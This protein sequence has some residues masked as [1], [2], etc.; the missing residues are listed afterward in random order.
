M[1]RFFL[2]ITYK[3]MDSNFTNLKEETMDNELLEKVQDLLRISTENVSVNHW[4]P[5]IHQDK[6]EG[7]AQELVKLF[8][9]HNVS[10]QR[11][12]LLDFLDN[13]GRHDYETKPFKQI[14]DEYL[15]SNNSG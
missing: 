14:V 10:Q 3:C 4:I 9:I 11:E 8:T 12:L 2:I 6:H 13:I 7:L 5:A 15:K 1:F